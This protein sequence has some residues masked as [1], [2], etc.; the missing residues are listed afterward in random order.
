MATWMMLFIIHIVAFLFLFYLNCNEVIH[1]CVNKTLS[2][3]K[4]FGVAMLLPTTA[5]YEDD[6]KPLKGQKLIYTTHL[7]ITQKHLYA[8]AG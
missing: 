6:D 2:L 4:V 8:V 1:N 3:Q 5:L 7:W